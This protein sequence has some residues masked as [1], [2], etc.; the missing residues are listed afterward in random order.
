MTK[1]FVFCPAVMVGLSP[2]LFAVSLAWAID[3]FFPA[4]GNK[5]YDVLHYDLDLTA[6]PAAQSLEGA[7]K[8]SIKATRQLRTFQLD[9]F[10]LKVASVTL[11]GDRV[12][13][14]QTERKLTIEPKGAIARGRP[15]EV[16]IRYGGTP[17]PIPDPTTPGQGVCRSAGY[18]SRTR[19]TR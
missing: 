12:R 1:P 18:I 14:S 7:A 10:R 5:G 6:D 16:V 2:S 17:T 11:D 3:P 9:L 13:F 4:Y 15:I 19:P 8:V